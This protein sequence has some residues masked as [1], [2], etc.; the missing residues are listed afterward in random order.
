MSVLV[1]IDGV[2]GT[3]KTWIAEDIAKYFGWQYLSCG[4]IYRAIAFY[5]YTMYKESLIAH[6]DDIIKQIE[7]ICIQDSSVG[8]NHIQ[9]NFSDL[10]R[11]E[12]GRLTTYFAQDIIVQNFIHKTIRKLVENE[13]YIVEG[14]EMASVF[15]EAKLH[16]YFYATPEA[17]I[18][19]YVEKNNIVVENAEF[20]ELC[21]NLRMIDDE[22][23]KRR[24]NPLRI[25]DD[26]IVVD[27]GKYG[28][29]HRQI[30]D[31]IVNTIKK[32]FSKSL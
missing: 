1:T 19:R 22:D 27:V 26:A 25:H 12:L 6:S 11:K 21:K 28:F 18:C 13:N 16:Y 7:D 3:F 31:Y 10:K 29:N 14:R 24:N 32:Q 17:R 9:Y 30:F 5:G 23:S 20:R 8:V 2:S 4:M 15:P